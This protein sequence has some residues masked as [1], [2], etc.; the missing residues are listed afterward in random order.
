MLWQAPLVSEQTTALRIR[1]RGQVQGVSFRWS[2]QQE[3]ER[4]GVAGWVR[5]ESDGTVAAHAEG[6]ADAVRALVEWCGQ[7]PDGAVVE[8]VETEPAEPEGGSGFSAG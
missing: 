4:L 3:A 1:V 8:D 5:N 2:C 6:S 7:G